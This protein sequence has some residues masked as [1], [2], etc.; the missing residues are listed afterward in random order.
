MSESKARTTRKTTPSLRDQLALK[1]AKIVTEYFPLGD[2]GEAAIDRFES[3]DRQVQLSE[4]IANRQGDKSDVDLDALR[5]LRDEA[6]AE[7]DKHCLALRFRGLS[8]DE[9]DALASEFVGEDVPKNAE[10]DERKRIEEEN[11]RKVKEW[12]YAALAAAAVDADL[13]AEEWRAELTTPG[14]WSAGDINRLRD[15]IQRAYG[16]QPA[17]GIPKG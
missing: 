9:R 4:V 16:A 8:E 3:L 7:R 1:R 15:A 13:T 11:D 2:D 12:T 5:K 10:P 6:A 14:K 17:D